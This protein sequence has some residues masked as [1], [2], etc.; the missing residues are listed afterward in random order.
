[1]VFKY[2]FFRDSNGNSF[3]NIVRNSCDSTDTNNLF[4]SGLVSM[5][6]AVGCDILFLIKGDR[7]CWVAMSIPRN[8]P[9]Q[10]NLIQFTP[11]KALE[12]KCCCS[13]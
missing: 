13:K 2:R 5:E 11:A 4:C 12:S 9:L 7:F 1:M 8:C 6:T 3:F 10:F